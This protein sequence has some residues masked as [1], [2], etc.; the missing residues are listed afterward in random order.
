MQTLHSDRIL[1]P[2]VNL[3]ALSVAVLGLFCGALHAQTFTVLKSFT[4]YDGAN[5][6]GTPILS[7]NTLYGTASSGGSGAYGIVYKLNTDGTGY[8]VLKSFDVAGPHVPYAKLVL[9]GSTLYGSTLVDGTSGYGA[10]FKINTDGTGYT[11]LKHFT[12]TDGAGPHGAMVLSGSTLYG[13]TYNGGASDSGTIFKINTNGT[14]FAMLKQFALTDG[15]NPAGDLVLSGSTLYGTTYSGGSDGLSGTIFKINTDGSG[16]TVLRT[17]AAAGGNHPYGGLVLS[18]TTLY[19]TAY[20]GGAYYCGTLFK[21]NTDGTGYTV[22]RTFDSTNGANPYAT[23]TLSGSTLYGTTYGGGSTYGLGALFQINTDGSGFAMLKGLAIT[24]SPICSHLYAGVVVSG[25]TLYGAS[26]NG[27]ANA[28]GTVF[29]FNSAPAAPAITSQPQSCTN[30]PGTTASFQV[31][32]TGTQPLSYR[33]RKN[34]L[35]LAD[36]GAITGATSDLLSLT[37][38]TTNYAGDFSVVITNVAGSVTSSVATL[39]VRRPPVA[40]TDAFEAP[41][42]ITV[43]VPTTTLLANDTDPSGEAINFAAVQSP[44]VGGVSVWVTSGKVTYFGAYSG[45][46]DRF[47]YTITNASGLTATGIVNVTLTGSLPATNQLAMQPLAGGALRLMYLGHATFR[48][49]LDR[50]HDLAPP[51]TWEPLETNWAGAQGYVVFTN[52]PSPGANNYYRIR[53]VIG[54]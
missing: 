32:A 26:C 6:Y 50:T 9:S 51:L 17:M 18:G 24:D 20:S 4:Y 2:L 33:W 46:T 48:Y 42:G 54:L 45:T 38:V 1:T 41:L 15:V 25:N 43:T 22:L 31:T 49:A 39:T 19:G 13:T 44:S 37:G 29:S 47:T 10:L 30:L 36:G 12:S 16:H 53:T 8:T 23:L 21:I 5:P 3:Y 14:G 35:N 27:G 52:A 34:G 7:G 40:G 11:I 28:S